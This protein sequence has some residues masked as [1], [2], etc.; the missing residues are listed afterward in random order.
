M[1]KY[2][3]YIIFYYHC[4]CHI[5]CRWSYKQASKFP[6]LSTK[7]SSRELNVVSHSSRLIL[8]CIWVYKVKEKLM[9]P[10]I[11]SSHTCAQ[12]FK[13]SRKNNSPIVI[14][15]TIKTIRQLDSLISTIPS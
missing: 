4:H 11:D 3:T 7:L 8:L 10:S 14:P 9:E 13:S 1:K 15:T 12:R 2:Y 5:H 6:T